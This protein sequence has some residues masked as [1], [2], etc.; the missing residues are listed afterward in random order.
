MPQATPT[1]TPPGKGKWWQNAKK[2][3]EVNWR[4]QKGVLSLD[5]LPKIPYYRL[6]IKGE[7]RPSVDPVEFI[8]TTCTEFDT[9]KQLEKILRLL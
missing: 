2:I 1:A 3:V 5:T 8:H 7:D 4:L 9:D 6:P